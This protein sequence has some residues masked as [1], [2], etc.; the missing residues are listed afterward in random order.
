MKKPQ[1]TR[2]GAILMC[3]RSVSGF[4]V[5]I[6]EAV[7]L[8][9]F[10]RTL[11]IDGQNLALSD[12]EASVVLA[13]LLGAYGFALLI[14]FVLAVFVFLGHNWARIMSMAY[15]T[16]SIVI[17][18]LGWW[19]NGVEI[20]LRTTLL[21]LALDILILLALSST[22]AREYARR[23]R[24]RSLAASVATATDASGATDLRPMP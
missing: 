16:F 7:F 17:A 22:T 6:V 8:K 14:Y 23:P 4:A 12:E 1:A 18:F 5:I 20:T 21:T 3:A 13:V 24:G 15:A 9:E 10:A 2:I 11:I 19:D